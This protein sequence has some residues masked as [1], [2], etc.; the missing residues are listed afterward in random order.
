MQKTTQQI[1]DGAVSKLQT[2]NS[3]SSVFDRDSGGTYGTLR[4]FAISFSIV[5]SGSSCRPPAGRKVVSASR[6]QPW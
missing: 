4:R 1:M 6:A 3:G 5:H 2:W